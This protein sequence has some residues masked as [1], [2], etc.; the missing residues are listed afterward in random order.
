MIAGSHVLHAGPDGLDHSRALV[1]EHDREAPGAQMAFS[2]VEVGVTHARRRHPN[3]DLARARRVEQHLLHGELR[4][5]LVR[6][7]GRN[8][9]HPTR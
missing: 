4:S 9:H 7:R 2:Q 6:H 8:A 5:G 3:Q 1:A